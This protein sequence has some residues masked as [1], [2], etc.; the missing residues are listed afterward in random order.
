LFRYT[1]VNLHYHCLTGL[2][3]VWKEREKYVHA[4]VS[5][6]HNPELRT[7]FLMVLSHEKG[8]AY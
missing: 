5:K 7:W 1:K 8:L 6:F 3:E 4:A 2:M